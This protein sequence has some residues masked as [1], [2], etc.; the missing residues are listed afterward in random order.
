MP[1]RPSQRLAHAQ[2]EATIA[3]RRPRPCSKERAENENGSQPQSILPRRR[4]TPKT[5]P[6]SARNRRRR[7]G[8]RHRC[9]LSTPDRRAPFGRPHADA[10][11]RVYA[12]GRVQRPSV[13]RKWKA[14]LHRLAWKGSGLSRTKWNC[15]A[16][17]RDWIFWQ[18]LCRRHYRGIPLSATVSVAL[19]FCLTRAYS[20]CQ[21]Q[22]RAPSRAAVGRFVC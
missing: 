19:R 14:G 12:A 6:R 15:L 21:W 9:S 17:I 8:H 16:R 7:V 1:A 10:E 11:Q 5:S 13:R 20:T 22:Q 18:Q 4:V 2:T 3:W